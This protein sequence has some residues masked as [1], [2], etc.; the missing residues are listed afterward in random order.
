MFFRN[1]VLMFGTATAVLVCFGWFASGGQLW[2]QLREAA[3]NPGRFL[4]RMADNA[5]L[6]LTPAERQQLRQAAAS[7]FASK[8]LLGPL[9]ALPAPTTRDVT[10]DLQDL[11]AAMERLEATSGDEA[12]VSEA[13]VLELRLQGV[14]QRALE[15]FAE[16]EARLLAAE[17]PE[18]ILARHDAA[19]AKY[20]EQMQRGLGELRAALQG[21][22]PAQL[23]A[24]L[25]SVAGHLRQSHSERPRSR[26]DP[27]QLP[28]KLP[29]LAQGE[30]ATL[31]ADAAPES[32]SR[33]FASAAKL[34]PPVP[35]DL[36]A[37][38]DVQ[39]TPELQALAASLGNNPLRIYEWVRNNIQFVPTYGSVQGSHMTYVA[40]R[41]N[42]FDISSL[43]MALLRS[44]GV[45]SRYVTGN[46]K[47]PAD[48]VMN[49]VGGVASPKVAQQLLGQGGVPNVGLVSGGTVTHLLIDH[50]WV[51][52]FVDN[53][54]SRGAVHVQGD[55]WVPLDAAFKLHTF[56]A[57]SNLFRDRPLSAVMQ[58]SDKYFEVDESLGRITQVD[59]T[60]LDQRL[61]TWAEQSDEYLLRNGFDGTLSGLV[62][63]K[64][65]IPETQSVLAGSLPYEV[66]VRNPAVSALPSSLRHSVTIR[67]FGSVLDR[68]AGSP[69]YSVKLSLPALNS[70]RLSLQFEPATAA[71]AQT[72]ESARMS[73]ATSLPVYLVNVVPVLK[74][75][76]VEAGR[77]SSIQ[78]G[79]AYAFDVVL[80]G[81]DDTSTVPYEVVAGDEIVIGVTGNGVSQEVLARRFASNPVDNA[82]EYF[83]QVALH[84]WME[85]DFLADVAARSRGVHML[86]L[87][88]VG[89][90]SSP[91]TVSYSFGS[92]RSG[93]YQGRSMD[94]KRSFMGAAGSDP[95]QVVAFM[96]Q[97][98]LSGSYLEGAV[99]DQLGSNTDPR[100]RGI[101]SVHLISA[102]ASQGIPIYY[103]TQANSASVLPRLALS[104]QVEGD[105]ATA[106]SHGKTVLVPERELDL[107][108]WSGV[109][110]IIQDETTGAGAYMISGG[111]SGGGILDCLRE[112]VPRFEV[113]LQ[114]FLFLIVLLLFALILIAVL[115]SGGTLAPAGAA[116]AVFLLFLLSQ[117]SFG[118]LGP[119]PDTV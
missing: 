9:R 92:P 79:S 29:R 51:E 3:D 36:L 13:S 32:D 6:A 87:P 73:G 68:A 91:L 101:S 106:L 111:L 112:L 18:V 44:A 48:E 77:G 89:V 98:G 11:A 25:A 35:A 60:V 63:G 113:V 8:P 7:G 93:V 50:V 22:N 109:G 39:L 4:E 45:S 108:A 19:V 24:A 10:A 118:P 59:G 40:R 31:P 119:S 67:G 28:F 27:A 33:R 74:V 100:I 81:P 49:W 14:H 103:I 52:A 64:D 30:P 72:L 75:D 58:P 5:R 90:F 55:T 2:A 34:T 94:V 84:Y 42:A 37:T 1:K 26:F 21:R 46:I 62:G 83:H 110:Y 86:R 16:T 102:A 78:M 85:C 117:R 107:G 115:G 116:A 23:K 12:L 82:S 104:S 114:F 20:R 76:G 97:A 53:V 41:G 54:P 80:Q 71:D 70:R 61:A 56:K 65:I 88:S 15:E 17:L 69:S 47:V 99:F 96:K 38:E 43:L 105:I 95:A 66:L 57:R